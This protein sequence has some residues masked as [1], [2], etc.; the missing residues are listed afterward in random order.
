LPVHHPH[1]RA[2]PSELERRREARWPGTND[3][4]RIVR[5]GHAAAFYVRA[6]QT[7]QS[8]LQS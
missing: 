7:Q 5:V 8:Q 6:P 1:R 2:E 3:E 4:N